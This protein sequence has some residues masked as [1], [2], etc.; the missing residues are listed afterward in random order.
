MKPIKQIIA[1][2]L[3]ELRKEN[4]LT[5]LELAEHLNYSDKAVSRWEQG[6]A[7]PDIDVLCRIAELYKVSF[8]YL[9]TDAPREEK[10]KYTAKSVGI[11]NKFT[12]TMLAI[13]LV[14]LVATIFFVYAKIIF[15]DLVWMSFVW[16]MPI[17]GLVALV[18]NSIWGNRRNNYLIISV[19]GWSLFATLYLQFLQHNIWPMFLLGVPMQL[20]VILWS[21]IKKKP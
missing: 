1:E 19:M 21:T 7:L 14:W 8:E 9:I 2:N 18:F 13:S 6:V 4:K 11:K 17:S 5:Q 10:Q 12:I 3:V 20:A 15:S 16:A